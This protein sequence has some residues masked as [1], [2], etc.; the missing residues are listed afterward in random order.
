MASW[1]GALK[2]CPF[3][4]W[5]LLALAMAQRC[6]LLRSLDLKPFGPLL[7]SRVGPAKAAKGLWPTFGRLCF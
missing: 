7:W 6:I 1:R 3:L 5:R 2:S 4:H